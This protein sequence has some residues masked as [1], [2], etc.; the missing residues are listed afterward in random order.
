[1]IASLFLV[2]LRKIVVFVVRRSV[3]VVFLGRRVATFVSEAFLFCLLALFSRQTVQI[4]VVVV[5][6][7]PD[8]SGWFFGGVDE[9]LVL[10]LRVVAANPTFWQWAALVFHGSAVG[11][12]HAILA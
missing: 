11:G 3:D 5:G 6:V 2:M 4:F 1:M 8:G 9:E 7:V 12:R 10:V